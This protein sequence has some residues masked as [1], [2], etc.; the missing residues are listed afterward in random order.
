MNAEIRS[1][2]AFLFLSVSLVAGCN[3]GDETAPD[4]IETNASALQPAPATY[5]IL[6]K[7]DQRKCVSPL[8]GG[9]FVSAVNLDRTLCANGSQAPECH[10]FRLDFTAAGIDPATA[11]AFEQDSFAQKHGLVRGRLVSRPF[12][13]GLSEDV[14]LVS[15]AWAGQALTVPRGTFRK[16]TATGRVCIT[17]PCDSFEGAKLNTNARRFFNAVDLAASGAPADAV[18]KGNEALAATGVLAAGVSVPIVGPAGHGKDFRASEFYLR[19]A[20][21]GRACASTTMCAPGEICT[22]ED[23][24]CNRP[25]GCAPG[26]ICPAVCY[27]TCRPGDGQP[28]AC[29]SDADCRTFS[30][31]CTGCD[32]R[33]LSV[34]QKDPVCPGPGVQCFV[35]PCFNK[36]AACENG[37]CVLRSTASQ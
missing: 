30:D 8:C 14:L 23:G 24:V 12:K 31:Y 5:F 28:A 26:A 35:D 21:G 11:A 10:A 3:A 7:L 18:A 15:E 29:K 13:G 9:Y 20:S 4:A 17:F 33:V 25:P 34:G 6:S 36:Q 22:T 19:V 1:V 2:T 16:L 32:C 27:G 37:Q